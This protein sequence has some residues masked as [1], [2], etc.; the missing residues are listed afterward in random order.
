MIQKSRNL[1]F[2]RDDCEEQT[3]KPNLFS[4]IYGPTKELAEKVLFGVEDVAQR[5]KPDSLQSIYVRPNARCGEVG[6]TLQKNECFC[7]LKSP[8][9]TQNMSLRQPVQR[10]DDPRG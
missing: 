10:S 4:I 3:L 1:A 5:L 7:N 2:G 6:R 8:V 9:P